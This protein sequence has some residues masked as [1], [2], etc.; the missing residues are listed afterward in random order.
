MEVR[1]IVNPMIRSNW[2]MIEQDRNFRKSYIDLIKK[3]N[4]IVVR[5]KQFE[6]AFILEDKS[7]VYL[8]M[9]FNCNGKEN[10]VYIVNLEQPNAP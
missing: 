8:T 3:L 9:E 5:S 4:P 2:N 1:T 10:I 7:I 6:E